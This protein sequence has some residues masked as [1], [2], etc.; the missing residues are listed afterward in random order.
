M[1]VSGNA[2][3]RENE[4][5]ATGMG[6]AQPRTAGGK[7]RYDTSLQL[8]EANDGH[9]ARRPQATP[10]GASPAQVWMEYKLRS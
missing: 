1:L 10:E 5:C 9:V 6:G 2:A 3:A 8:V 4:H 7:G